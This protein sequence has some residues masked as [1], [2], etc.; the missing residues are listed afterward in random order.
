K[1]CWA[2]TEEAGVEEA[3]R[4]WANAGVPGELAQVLPSPQHFEQVSELVA[5]E[6]TASS[7]ACGPDLEKHLES[8]QPAIDA[9]FEELYVSNMGRHYREMLTAY[10]EKGL[11]ELRRRAGA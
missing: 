1:V 2:P 10:G 6:S 9:G 4:L 3:H 7:V 11:P 5:K 8:L